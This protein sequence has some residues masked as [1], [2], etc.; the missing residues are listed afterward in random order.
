M[1]GNNKKQ[2]SGWQQR[3]GETGGTLYQIPGRNVEGVLGRGEGA[4]GVPV[5]NQTIISHNMQQEEVDALQKTA[6]TE[7]S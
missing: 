1:V 6:A 4:G 3:G 7:N 5:W 2:Q